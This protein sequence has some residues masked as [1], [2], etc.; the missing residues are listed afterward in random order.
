MEV[1]KCGGQLGASRL[2]KGCRW[3]AAGGGETKVCLEDGLDQVCLKMT[4]GK[5]GIQNVS[6]LR[7]AHVGL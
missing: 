5:K 6:Q 2:G 4:E 3:V 7:Q 1:W